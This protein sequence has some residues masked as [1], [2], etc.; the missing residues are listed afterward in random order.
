MVLKELVKFMN[1]GIKIP[2]CVRYPAIYHTKFLLKASSHD[3][4]LENVH[5]NG[6]T[7]NS[8]ITHIY[9]KRAEIQEMH[10]PFWS[11]SLDSEILLEDMILF[12]I[13][14]T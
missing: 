11:R 6:K 3:A 10:V 9:I 14:R 13:L 4:Y 5:T 2:I 8:D 1:F 12:S 7:P